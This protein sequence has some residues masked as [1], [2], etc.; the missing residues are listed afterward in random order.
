M[1]YF[2]TDSCVAMFK[3][4]KNGILK[5]KSYRQLDGQYFKVVRQF[6]IFVSSFNCNTSRILSIFL[7]VTFKKYPS[8]PIFPFWKKDRC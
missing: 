5:E 1:K 7:I 8:F 2:R 4:S 3:I 6:R